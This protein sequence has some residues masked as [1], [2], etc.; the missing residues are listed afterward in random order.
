MLKI[1]KMLGVVVGILD[2]SRRCPKSRRDGMKDGRRVKDEKSSPFEICAIKLIPAL[3]SPC[4]L[5]RGLTD[6][7]GN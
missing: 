4:S 2:A 5:T 6:F 3:R 7:D 1:E